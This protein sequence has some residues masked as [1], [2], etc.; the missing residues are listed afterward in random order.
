MT[1]EDLVRYSVEEHTTAQTPPQPHT[2]HL[3]QRG[4]R[5]ATLTVVGASV[6]VAAL[7][8]STIVG[9]AAIR[10]DAA[11]PQPTN[12]SSH[13]TEDGPAPTKGPNNVYLYGDGRIAMN[14]KVYPAVSGTYFHVA[15][16]GLQY[17]DDAGRAHLLDMD[18]AP[19]QLAPDTPVKAGAKYGGWVAADSSQPLVVW[20]EEAIS[21]KGAAAT[22][23]VDLVLFDTEQMREIGRRTE[24]CRYRKAYQFM[25]CPGA[26][27]VSDGL[28]FADNNK[29]LFG[30]NP[31]GRADGAAEWFPLNA[32]FA[33]QAHHKSV[34]KFDY[35]G[36]DYSG[37][38]STW[39]VVPAAENQLLSYD[40]R[41]L[42]EGD[43]I[44]SVA[45]PAETVTFDPPG[46]IEESQFDPSG[47]VLFTTKLGSGK[48]QVFACSA[49]TVD[50]EPL[51]EVAAKPFRL[52]NWDS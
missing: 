48:Y 15:V 4:R 47:S 19:V 10:D 37:L 16:N 42:L 18:G 6:G 30:W 7:T 29:G 21:G 39:T 2:D 32:D 38:P 14:G 28:V 24:P 43:T 5:R 8:I 31:A 13:G 46:Q 23:T 27:V 1:I 51:S 52:V 12:R 44:T 34:L 40:G 26:Y 22:G 41:W 50:C 25:S 9:V 17:T 49:A 36:G 20:T 11:G 35:E 45:Q 33:M 3:V